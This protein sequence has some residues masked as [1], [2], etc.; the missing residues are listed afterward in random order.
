[1]IASRPDLSVD[2]T[3]RC[4]STKRS[5]LVFPATQRQGW[6]LCKEGARHASSTALVITPVSTIACVMCAHPPSVP[7]RPSGI[8]TPHARVLGPERHVIG[9][10]TNLGTTDHRH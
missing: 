4:G 8:R 9:P 5:T 3:I 6:M 7:L 1:M 2:V 10:R